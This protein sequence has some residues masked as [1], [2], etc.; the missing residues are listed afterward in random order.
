M[1]RYVFTGP[2]TVFGKVVSNK[3]YGETMAISEM[4][5]R[6]IRIPV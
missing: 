3:W 2:V 6:C 4:K 1:N 5:A